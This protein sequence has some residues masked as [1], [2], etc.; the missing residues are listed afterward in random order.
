MVGHDLAALAREAQEM[1]HEII[2]A[3]RRDLLMPYEM[4]DRDWLV[5]AERHC[6]EKWPAVTELVREFGATEVCS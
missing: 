2:G 5:A 1:R 4:P 3:L 6:D